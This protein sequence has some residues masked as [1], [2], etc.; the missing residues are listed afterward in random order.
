VQDNA[1][2]FRA[3]IRARSTGCKTFVGVERID[4]TKG[5]LE[6]L[7]AFDKLFTDR[8]ELR[9]KVVLLQLAAPSRMQLD[10][11]RE[12]NERIDALVHDINARHQTESWQPIFFLK[13]HH[14]YYAVLAAYTMGDVLLATSLHDGMNLVAKEY[15]AA[16]SDN[17]GVLVLSEYTGAA[18]ELTDA[19]LVNPF[20]IEQ[21]AEAMY[22][23]YSMTPEEVQLRMTRLRAHA[24][25]EN[26][27]VWGTRVFDEL[28]K[29]LLV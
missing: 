19:V 24:A 17:T 29:I 10:V 15:V 21:V 8:P 6:R 9:G 18:R 23:A 4:Y 2:E 12:L 7:Q 14:D 11:Y 26:V 1:R 13:A 5:L 3:V 28:R 22:Q 25:A 27:Y 16:R 20:D